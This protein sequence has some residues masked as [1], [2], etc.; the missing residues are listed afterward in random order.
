MLRFSGRSM[1]CCGL[2]IVVAGRVQRLVMAFKSPFGELKACLTLF[3]GVF[4][5]LQSL[6][7]P[8]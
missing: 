3:L 8:V 7:A 2:A 4:V 1:R 6:Q 5:N